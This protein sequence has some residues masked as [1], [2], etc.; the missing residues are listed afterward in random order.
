VK[1]VFF[2]PETSTVISLLSTVKS[3]RQYCASHIMLRDWLLFKDTPEHVDS[4]NVYL[5]IR[6]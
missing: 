6:M 3:V 4:E 1:I 5:V 2:S